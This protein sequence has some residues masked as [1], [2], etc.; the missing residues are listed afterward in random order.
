MYLNLKKYGLS[1]RFEQEAS[2]YRNLFPARITEQHRD[3][4]KV[5]CEHG[6][7][8]AGISGNLAYH[9]EDL[10]SFPAV[11][12]WVM[13]DRTDSASGNAVI[14]NILGRKSVFVRQTAGTS[15]EQ[16]VVAANI[17][18]I[19]ICMSLNSDFNVR[20][21]ERY[22]T[23]AW[24]SM[25]APVIV[26]TKS[27]LCDNLEE[28]L[29][30]LSTVSLGIDVIVCSSENENGYHD[31]NNYIAEG[32]TIAFIGSSGVGKSTLI[33]RLAGNEDQV[34]S[35]IRSGDDKGKH[36][37]TYRQLKLLPNGGIV[38]DTPGMRELQL[39]SGD[40]SKTFEDIEEFAAQC[41]YKNCS[42][43]SEP[44][45]MV[46]EAI[47][48]GTL[49][50]KRFRNYQKLQREM[51]YSNLNSRQTEQEKINRMFGSKKEMKKVMKQ[52]KN[53]KSR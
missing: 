30:E 17:D 26:L 52:M 3:L 38:I 28:K 20:R 50:E 9:A 8:I 47:E 22:L 42:H 4:Y 12:D 49:S 35:E 29:E 46:R 7:L 13:I 31:V 51:E 16:Q 34:V 41:K 6:E 11:G 39:Y 14:K 18:T 45:C 15:N 5:M 10:M 44:G 32:K 37:T 36:T 53:K 48:N 2:L 43:T 24:D 21:I 25:A 19:F 40:L 27:D 33:N 23:V 1:D